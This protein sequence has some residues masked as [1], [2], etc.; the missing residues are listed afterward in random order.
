MTYHIKN[1][2]DLDAKLKEAGGNLVVIDFHASWCGPCKLVAPKVEELAKVHPDIMFL[3]VD[4]DECEDIASQ[5]EISVMPTFVFIKNE[6][7]LE[8]FSGGN[9]EKLQETTL[10]LK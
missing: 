8:S 10:R 4:V 6:K 5:Y 2:A 9:F 1:K 3:K 7:K